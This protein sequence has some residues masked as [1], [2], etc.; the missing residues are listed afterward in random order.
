MEN[1]SKALLIA[2]G[3]LIT[4]I[5]ASFGV[6]L[7][8]VYHAHS[9]NMLAAMSEKEISQFNAKFLAYEGRNLTP[10]EV[11]SLVNLAKQSGIT[12]TDIT[13]HYSETGQNSD[14]DDKEVARKYFGDVNKDG[15]YFISKLSKITD[16]KV[17]VT[18]DDGTTSEETQKGYL[19]YF[20][21]QSNSDS[22]SNDT[23]K[24]YKV[25]I[26]M[27]RNKT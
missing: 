6:Y 17:K 1:A 8:G 19:Y 15:N 11:V 22:Y 20:T 26:A 14:P 5:V 23:G 13:L 16:I 24:I 2:G 3:V 7:Y 4:M 12:Y 21:Y 9:E 18:N 10:N 27:H 25:I